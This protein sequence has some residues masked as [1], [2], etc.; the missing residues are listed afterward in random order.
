MNMFIKK[1][2]GN[3]NK[4]TRR[5]KQKEETRQLILTVAQKQF[6]ENGF[7]KTTMRS[8]AEEAEIAVG[9]IF[10]HF[11]DK[12]ALLAATFYEIIA[13]QTEMAFATLPAEATLKAKLLHMARSLYSYYAQDVTLSRTLLK[14]IL[15]MDGEWGDAHNQQ[16]LTFITSLAEWLKQEQE[17]GT[18][19]REANVTIIATSFFSHYLFVLI[20]GL[21]APSFAVDA[22][23]AQLDALISPILN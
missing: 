14:E 4:S 23:I 15:F 19:N 22:Q 3:T 7:A 1:I 8:I 20:T 9:T 2:M 5:N 10:V 18:L 11:A 21:R 13:Q 12:S 6:T 17:N 16:A